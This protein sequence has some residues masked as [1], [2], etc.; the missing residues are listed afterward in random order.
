MSHEFVVSVGIVLWP[1]ALALRMRDSHDT[2]SR[3]ILPTASVVL[4]SE[5]DRATACLLNG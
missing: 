2:S 1:C 3:D 4:E 5:G